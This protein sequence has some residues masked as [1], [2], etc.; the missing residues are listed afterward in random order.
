LGGWFSGVSGIVKKNLVFKTTNAGDNWVL[1]FEDTFDPGKSIT[2]ISFVNENVGIFV[3]NFGKYYYTS[4]GGEIWEESYYDE[5]HIGSDVYTKLY[6]PNKD[7]AF[8][9]NSNNTYR[10]IAESGSTIYFQDHSNNSDV[11][12]NPATSQ[13]TLFL[14]EEFISAPE[15]DIID[16]LGNVK[17]WTPSSRWS[18]SEKTI[19]INT[20]SLSPGVYFLR[21]RSGE[22]V[23]VRKFVVL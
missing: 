5:E 20:S 2:D 13:I 19:T 18:P 8:I 17:R 10:S 7:I 6:F 12:P 1:Q 4:D 23:E 21:I 14:G 15:I 11:F 3:T 9:Q 16:Y 22:R